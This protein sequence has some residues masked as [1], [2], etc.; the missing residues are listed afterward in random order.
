MRTANGS[1]LVAYFLLRLILL[2]RVASQHLSTGDIE[3][4]TIQAYLIEVRS[5]LHDLA[6]F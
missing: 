2:I 6:V 4:R 5:E 1:R 3:V